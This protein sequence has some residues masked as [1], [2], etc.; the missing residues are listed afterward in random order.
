MT[1]TSRAHRG[2]SPGCNS[3]SARWRRRDHLGRTEVG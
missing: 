3:S 1:E 2:T